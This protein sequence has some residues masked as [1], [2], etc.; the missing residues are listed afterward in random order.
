[1]TKRD[2]SYLLLLLTLVLWF[3]HEMVWSDKVPFF[4]DLSTYFYPIR[5]S[6]AESFKVG[7]LPLWDRHMAMG[8]P[9]LADFQSA[10]FYPPHL[11]FLVF[12]FFTAIRILYLFHYMVAAAGGYLLCRRWNYPP[13]LALVGALLFTLGGTVVSLSNLLNHFQAAVWLPAVLL[14]GERLL[15]NQSWKNFLL[16]TLMLVLQFLA[17]SPEL[18]AMSVAL[19]CLDGLRIR[20]TEGNFTWRR[21]FSLIAAANV[22]VVGLAMVQILPTAELYLESRGRDPIVYP[23]AVSWSLHP[24]RLL[25]LFFLDNEVDTTLPEGVRLFLVPEIPFFISHYLGAIS[26]TG[27]SLWLFYG[28]RKEKGV[29]LGLIIVSLAIALGRHTPVYPFLFQHIPFSGIIRFPEKFFFLTYGFLFFITLR[30]LYDFFKDDHPADKRPLLILSLISILWV[31]VYLFFRFETASLVQLIA[32]AAQPPPSSSTLRVASGILFSLERQT[33]LML[34]ILLIVALWKTGKIR[35]NLFQA[36]IVGLVFFDLTSA[37]RP[38]QYLLEADLVFKSPRIIAVPNPERQRLFYYPPR[39]NLHPNYYL[40]P[41]RP[42]F[43]EVQGLLFSNLFPNLGI[44]HGFDYMQEID[45]LPRWPYRT[46]LNFANNLSPD[47]QFRLL[48]SLN[49][50]YIIALRPLTHKGVT[51]VRHF[52]EHP[53][54][55]YKIDRIIPRAYIASKVIAEGD[56]YKILE[57]LSS[58]EFDPLNEVILAGPLSAPAKNNIQAKAEIVSYTDHRVRIRALLDSPGVLVLA[59][60]F[61]PGWRVYVDGE[62]KEVLRANLF[63]RGV[64]LAPGES[65]VE[66]RYEPRSFTV[67]L[68]I[69]LITIGGLAIWSI[70]GWVIRRKKTIPPV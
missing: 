56:P 16:L 70:H 36:L 61:Y 29:F 60:S 32:W 54:W 18:Y 28:T 65:L 7:E 26:L 41:R 68:A 46:F 37:H 57:R 23:E 1:M 67:G 8:Y 44:F 15:L 58:E 31:I 59:D 39:T 52:P 13:Y 5:F 38:Y 64:P 21:V 35:T 55:L 12:P 4:R 69:S 43:Q 22:L 11:F 19:L 62:E 30:G 24:L 48:G 2:A 17:G 42:P 20:A 49:V 40:I 66:F 53:S 14:M 45:A 9:L 51:L 47:K 33:A 25:N 63:F 27:I 10:A 6:L 34:G 3:S 50:K